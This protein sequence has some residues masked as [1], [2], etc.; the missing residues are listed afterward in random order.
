MSIWRYK[1][2][3]KKTSILPNFCHFLQKKNKLES[4]NL[5]GPTL[6]YTKRSLSLA[7]NVC[8]HHANAFHIFG[9]LLSTE[10]IK[11]F[12][13]K[14]WYQH[15]MRLP[16]SS[17]SS[18]LLRC[19]CLANIDGKW[20][21]IF[22]CVNL[23]SSGIFLTA[24]CDASI[25]IWCLNE[26]SD[27]KKGQQFHIEYYVRLCAKD[28]CICVN[29]LCVPVS[30]LIYQSNGITK[31]RNWLSFTSILGNCVRGLLHSLFTP[32]G[33]APHPYLNVAYFAL[34]M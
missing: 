26:E 3:Q 6:F 1:S 32:L 16:S 5:I 25:E 21:S 28:V 7:S 4:W 24:F 13:I 33:F 18:Y 34:F 29:I 17:L 22:P 8:S 11:M 2:T 30:H 20:V 27:W 9:I 23:D 14:S 10:T 31:Q 15:F 12:M 19:L